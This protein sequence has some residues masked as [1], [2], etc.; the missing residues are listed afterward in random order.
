MDVFRT[1]WSMPLDSQKGMSDG[2][3]WTTA[4]K[5]VRAIVLR[6]AS[7]VRK[8]ARVEIIE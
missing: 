7:E 3:N 4:P 2:E 5:G 6:S 1:A 8:M